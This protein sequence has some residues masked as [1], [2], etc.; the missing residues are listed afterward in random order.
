MIKLT[1]ITSKNFVL[2]INPFIKFR[3]KI[4]LVKKIR[5]E[6]LR[7]KTCFIKLIYTI[8]SLVKLEIKKKSVLLAA[9]NFQRHD[10]KFHR[11]SP[12][13]SPH[14]PPPPLRSRL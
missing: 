8:N 10:S 2:G 13:Q 4:W 14:A 9:A 3:R 11:R 6:I 5:T 7:K 12:P 1:E